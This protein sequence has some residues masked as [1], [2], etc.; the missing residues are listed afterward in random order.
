M[1]VAASHDA[2]VYTGQWIAI[3]RGQVVA[4]GLSAHEALLNCRAMRLKDEPVLRYI[5]P[6]RPERTRKRKSNERA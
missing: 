4:S 1:P 3:V 6:V 5:P 2:S